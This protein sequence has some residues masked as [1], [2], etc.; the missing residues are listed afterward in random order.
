[1]DSRYDMVIA[2]GVDTRV[3]VQPVSETECRVHLMIGVT[4][5]RDLIAGELQGIRSRIRKFFLGLRQSCPGLPL[6]VIPPLAEG[7]DRLA[8]EVAHELEIPTV[9][10]LPM[11]R[12]LYQTDFE[13]GSLTQ[14][15]EMLALA[16]EVIE[17]PLLAD[18]SESDVAAQGPARN[19][20]YAQLGAY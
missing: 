15:E 14:F 19:V 9:V 18:V 17:L 10:L 3:D 2:G 7:A 4:G 1:M 16:D 6:K 11:P 13:A 8:A 5:H 20:Q 12:R